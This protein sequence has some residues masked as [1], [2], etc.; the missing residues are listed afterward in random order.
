MAER[1]G[2]RVNWLSAQ[3]TKLAIAATATSIGLTFIDSPI[4]ETADRITS[5]AKWMIPSLI[6]GEV[7]WIGGGAIMLAAVGSKIKNP[8]KIKKMVPEIA[9]RAN[10]SL[11]FKSGFWV[12]TIAA[13][14]EF[15][16]MTA[17]V[18]SEF[19]VRSWGLA[20]FGLA[21]LAVTIAVRR[22]IRKGI[23]K[24]ISSVA[25]ITPTLAG[26]QE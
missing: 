4:S 8:F 19:P 10:D 5:A 22:A 17:G 24:N 3:K 26:S 7:A 6:M 2:P 20:S 18:T 13:V 14:A 12:N 25:V 9:E 15:G 11:L 21:D 16:I 1:D 23:R